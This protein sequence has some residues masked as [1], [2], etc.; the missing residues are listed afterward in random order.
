MLIICA[1]GYLKIRPETFLVCF[2]QTKIRLHAILNGATYYFFLKDLV[3]I[4]SKKPENAS[5][6][7][8]LH[9]ILNGATC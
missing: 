6:L 5:V 7:M 4:C 3:N 9:T 1:N 2:L 8:G